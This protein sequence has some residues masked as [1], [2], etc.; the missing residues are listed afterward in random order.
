M[1][2]GSESGSMQSLRNDI[3]Y[4]YDPSLTSPSGLFASPHSKGG[5]NGWTSPKLGSP[6]TQPQ[7]GEPDGP[8]AP[9]IL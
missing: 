8:P 5:S 9:P 4:E 1:S 7:G 2:W 3:I 6:S